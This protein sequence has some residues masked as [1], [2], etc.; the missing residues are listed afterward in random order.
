MVSL[1]VDTTS[2]LD[3]GAHARSAA[4][5]VER[6]M[7]RAVSGLS[8]SSRMAG[9]DPNGHK[10]AA[11]YDEAC[12]QLVGYVAQLQDAASTLSR[13][14]AVTG[15]YY[16]LTELA[17]AGLTDVAIEMPAPITAA[18]RPHLPSA[19]GGDRKFPMA[20]PVDEWIV[21]Q[22]ANLVGDMWPDGDT[23]K[24]DHASTVWHHLAD[25]LDDAAMSLTKVSHAL[26]GVDTPELPR[27]QDEIDSVRKFAK[28]LATACRSVGKACNDL[29][30]QI[31]HVHVQTGITIGITVT[32]I[33]V[34]AAAG[35]GLTVVT[36]G[37]S[38][39]A[40]AGGVAAEVGGAVA[41]ITGFIA[42]LASTISVGVGLIA[43]S[44][45]GLVGVSADMAATIGVTVGDISA[46][47]VLWG[48][49]G[50]TEDVIA[51][52]VTEP[53]GDLISA[54]EDGFISGAIGGAI[55]QGVVKV[56]QVIG[57]SGRSPSSSPARTQ[58]ARAS[59]MTC[60]RASWRRRRGAVR[61]RQ[62]TSPRSTSPS[63]SPSSRT[64]APDSSPRSSS[65]SMA[66][67]NP[68]AQRSW[69]P[70]VW[71]TSSHGSRTAT[72]DC[73]RMRSGSRRVNSPTAL[74]CGSTFLRRWTSAAGYLRGMRPVRIR[75]GSREVTFR[76]GFPRLSSTSE[77]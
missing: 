35:L 65:T 18:S 23:G 28:K 73:S 22:I 16:E 12:G 55:G 20:N 24:L 25:D 21:E 57:S 56:V 38:D 43:E 67:A 10:W 68:T 33:A 72:R 61:I 45:A 1:L 27:A 17:N 70:R 47:A 69:C 52:A 51:T 8:G 13:K 46:S 59:A 6:A 44:A 37:V 5:A 49:A 34:T 29:S 31:A 60:A 77:A 64:A 62:R 71:S 3:A 4:L 66:S 50:A 19:A 30:G 63:I 15:Y 54:A 7:S 36:F 2:F 40:A 39:V 42:E 58:S 32:A 11:S 53:D 14:L 74:L 41:T 75:N 26:V 76:T 9:S 48:A